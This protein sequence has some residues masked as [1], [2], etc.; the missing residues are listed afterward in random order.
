[1]K[2]NWYLVT[3]SKTP[4]SAWEASSG[5]DSYKKAKSLARSMAFD[6]NTEAFVRVA[7]YIRCGT[8]EHSPY[9]FEKLS[10]GA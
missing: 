7:Q 8:N 9:S 2:N 4:L 3:R 5:L 10:Y 1:M 6:P